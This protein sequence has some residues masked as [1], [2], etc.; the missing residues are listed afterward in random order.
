MAEQICMHVEVEVDVAVAVA[1]SV[2]PLCFYVVYPNFPI[3]DLNFLPTPN[4]I[5]LTIP[6]TVNTPP[7]M[8]QIWTKK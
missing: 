4:A 6:N 2:L 5:L 7:I 3:S 8:A 1:I